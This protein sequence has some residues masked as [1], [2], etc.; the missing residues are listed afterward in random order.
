MTTVRRTLFGLLLIVSCW[1]S[2]S[3]AES[4]VA[5]VIGNSHY[6]HAP[7]L[8]NPANDA[9]AVAALLRRSGFDRVQVREDV[10]VVELRRSIREFSEE[11]KTAD[12]AVVYFAG[13]GIE[14]D[15]TNF[16]IP[17][18][19][20]LAS[21]FDVEDE[22]LSL[23]RVLRT[24]E[25]A[26]RLRLVILDACRENPFAAKMKR[27]VA[28]R[29]ITRGL[30]KIEPATTD[31]LIAFAAKAGAVAEDG[32]NRNSPFT[33]ALLKHLAS[34][35]LDLRIAFGRVR[36]DVL[37]LTKGKQEP[38]VYGSLGGSTVS[39]LPAPVDPYAED[40]QAFEG[41]A[42][43]GTKDAWRAFLGNH[44][45]GLYADL[46]RTQLA[47]LEAVEA[48]SVKADAASVRA[49]EARRAVEER[50]ARPSDDAAQQATA[51]INA[52]L[53]VALREREDARRQADEARRQ[54]E[55][56][57]RAAVEDA[58]RLSE[59]SA[60]QAA[61]T[62]PQ[63]QSLGLAPSLGRDVP[64]SHDPAGLDPVDL[65]RLLQV[66]LTRV[67]C[68]PKANDGRWSEGSRSALREFNRRTGAA[69]DVAVPTFA[70]LAAVRGKLERVCPLT[71]GR[72]EKLSGDQCVAVKQDCA[73]GETL[74]ANGRCKKRTRA[75][76]KPATRR[77][78]KSAAAP[79]GSARCFTFKGKRF[80][81]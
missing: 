20:R 58:N 35:G 31:T 74:G 24:L 68:D 46:A 53:D 60:R 33:A 12:I 36:D 6:A 19:A 23:D 39:L 7:T 42:Q 5:L 54:L 76:E 21:D 71:C 64:V 1:P 8:E 10:G 43:V 66:H 44:V 50:R 62:P 51:R 80:C 38:F 48:A 11:A 34:P 78:A 17:V 79:Q 28:T 2:G 22:T 57:K 14:V 37:T 18:D 72:G 63:S 16:L 9:A 29:A 40:R 81:E 25:P 69:F 61:L 47:R 56:V 49:E 26:K 4:R 55:E 27:S 3:F 32:A 75:A 77:A 15:G 30:A 70:A 67:G 41:A 52:Q 45:K 65:A 13:H 59:E 73:A